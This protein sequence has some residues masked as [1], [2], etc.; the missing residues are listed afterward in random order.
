MGEVGE[1]DPA[2]AVGVISSCKAE[3]TPRPGEALVEVADTGPGIPA[4]QLPYVFDRLWRGSAP[5][6]EAAAASASP[7]PSPSP[8]S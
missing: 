7:S 6:P 2:V 5:A 1:A 4:G 8:K 3:E